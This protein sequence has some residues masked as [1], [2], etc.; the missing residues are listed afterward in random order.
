MKTLCVFCGSSRGHSLAYARAA[1]TFGELLA[2]EGID[3]VWGGGHVGLMGVLA[4]AVLDAGGRALGVIPGFMAEREL[5]HPRASELFI[6]D[7]MHAR[8]AKMA[9]LAEGFAVLPGGFGSLEEF[10]EVLTW[11]QLH[12]HHKPIGLLDVDAFFEPVLELLQHLVRQGF[13]RAANL[14]LVVAES[15]PQALLERLRA[16][17][18]AE[19]DWL[20]KVGLE[21]T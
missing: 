2:C 8:K 10:F 11:A 18:A 14:E 1:R 13:V 5:S 4:D 6:V 12:L 16:Y 17:P 20:E 7:S 3:L 19:G 9:E 15:E 21:S